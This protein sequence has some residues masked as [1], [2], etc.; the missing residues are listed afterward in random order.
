VATTTPDKK[1]EHARPL[2]D[3]REDE[4]RLF[5]ITFTGGLAANVGLVVVLALGFSR[6]VRWR[7]SPGLA[8]RRLGTSS[9]WRW[10]YTRSAG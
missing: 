2:W 7:G 9:S 4:K 10:C 3:L 1:I 5:A 8:T 6:P